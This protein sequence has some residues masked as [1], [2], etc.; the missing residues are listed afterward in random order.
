MCCVQ[1]KYQFPD[2]RTQQTAKPDSKPD[3]DPTYE[4]FSRDDPNGIVA[5]MLKY[6]EVYSVL[7]SLHPPSVPT[8]GFN[9]FLQMT[10][11]TTGADPALVADRGRFSFSDVAARNNDIVARHRP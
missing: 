2:H 7:R 9:L 10:K 6:R 1:K 3:A 5:C 11:K 4:D 8:Q